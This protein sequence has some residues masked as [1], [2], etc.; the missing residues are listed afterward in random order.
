MVGRWDD[1]RCGIAYKTSETGTD[2]A[3]SLQ[4]TAPIT[5]RRSFLLHWHSRFI[6]AYLSRSTITPPWSVLRTHSRCIRV[7]P[8]LTPNYIT[9]ASSSDSMESSRRRRKTGM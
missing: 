7:E 6:T 8:I 5:P 9:V 4:L 3:K 1:L 2:V